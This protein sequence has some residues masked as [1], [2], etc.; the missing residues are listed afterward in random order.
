MD[1]GPALL[2][3]YRKT[4]GLELELKL[5]RFST[6]GAFMFELSIQSCKSITLNQEGTSGAGT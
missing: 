1:V 4:H 3:H 6:Q 5:R 2:H